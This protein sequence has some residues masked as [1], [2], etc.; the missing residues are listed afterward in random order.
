MEETLI[1]Y[2]EIPEQ[3]TL[4]FVPNSEITEEERKLLDKVA[5]VIVN[6]AGIPQEDIDASN[7]LFENYLD[8]KWKQYKVEFP[9]KVISGKHITDVV[10]TGIMM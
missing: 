4:F 6:L 2:E 8:G 7:E 5:G 3:T 10:I 1:I 9:E